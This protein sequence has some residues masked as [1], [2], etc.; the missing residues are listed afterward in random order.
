MRTP[1][2]VRGAA[3]NRGPYRHPDRRRQTRGLVAALLEQGLPQAEIA[4][5]LGLSAAAVAYHRRALGVPVDDRCNRRYDWSEIQAFYDQG[6]SVREC[7]S[8]FGFSLKTFHDARLRGAVRTRPQAMSLES[9]LSAPRNRNHLK[10]R[11]IKLGLKSS[12][13][14]ECGRDE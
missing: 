6:H 3:G 11:L 9:L 14:E 4:R 13:C 1:G 12:A 2:S 10:L 8:R 5:L 7:Q